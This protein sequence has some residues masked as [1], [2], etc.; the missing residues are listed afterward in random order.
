MFCFGIRASAKE[1]FIS[2]CGEKKMKKFKIIYLSIYGNKLNYR[3]KSETYEEAIGILMKKRS[4]KVFK[5][6]DWKEKR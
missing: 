5:I 3:T 4:Y 2:E 6:L 1:V